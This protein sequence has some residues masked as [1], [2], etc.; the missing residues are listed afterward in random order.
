[1]NLS[2]DIGIV[3]SDGGGGT[4]SPQWTACLEIFFLLVAQVHFAKYS[5]TVV[6]A[7][8]AAA[9]MRA[10]LLCGWTNADG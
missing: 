9:A 7:A 3:Q 2:S 5:P 6:F 1:M 10:V 4:V 8:A